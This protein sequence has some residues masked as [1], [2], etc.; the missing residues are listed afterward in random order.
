VPVWLS[1][2]PGAIHRR[3]PTLGEHTDR[4]MAELGYDAAAIA[5]L[6]Q[7]GVI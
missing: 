1:E 6:R 4:I 3:P 5:S 2:T 7:A